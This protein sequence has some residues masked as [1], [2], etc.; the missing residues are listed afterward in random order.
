[1]STSVT[2][3]SGGSTVIV[4]RDTKIGRTTDFPSGG[5]FE[6]SKLN[7]ELDTLVAI[8]SDL[9]DHVSRSIRLQD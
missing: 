2:G 6:V 8:D 7:T 5:A 3:A 1:M 4:L 9:E